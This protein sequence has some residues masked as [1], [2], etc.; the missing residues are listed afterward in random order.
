VRHT[1]RSVDNDNNN[2]D[3]DDDD[4]LSAIPNDAEIVTKDLQRRLRGVSSDALPIGTVDSKT[5]D[6]RRTRT[7]C[8][9]RGRACAW[10]GYP[11][12]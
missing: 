4:Q 3:Y 8:Q 2:T 7:A 9:R 12:A 11:S 5:P 1:P 6:T 10:P